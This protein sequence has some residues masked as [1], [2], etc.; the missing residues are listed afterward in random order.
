MNDTLRKLLTLAF[1]G[2]LVAGVGA[3]PAAAYHESS[4]S[5]TTVDIIG[6]FQDNEQTAISVVDQ[7]QT[8]DQDNRNVQLAGG[9][10]AVNG[11]AS[12]DQRNTQVNA[13]A[14][15]GLSSASNSNTQN[16]TADA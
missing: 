4:Y 13:N 7:N 15:V 16:Q 10:V 11:D 6:Q 5:S 8:V 1:V 3:M 2:A 12:T 14:Q 9:S